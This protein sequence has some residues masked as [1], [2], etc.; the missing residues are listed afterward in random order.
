MDWRGKDSPASELRRSIAEHEGAPTE[1]ADARQRMECPK[2]TALE[3]ERGTGNRRQPCARPLRQ[4]LGWVTETSRRHVE[5]ARPLSG[6][7]AMV[8][9]FQSVQ[10]QA[11]ITNMLP[12]H[13]RYARLLPWSHADLY[14]RLLSGLAVATWRDVVSRLIGMSSPTPP[15]EGRLGRTMLVSGALLTTALLMFST[16]LAG[17]SVWLVGHDRPGDHLNRIPC[18]AMRV[19]VAPR[20]WLQIFGATHGRLAA[21]RSRHCCLSPFEPHSC[22]G[23]TTAMSPTDKV[24]PD[25]N[26]LYLTAPLGAARCRA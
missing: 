20:G 6:Q 7:H 22:P 16:D 3:D 9:I 21:V 5:G 18:H 14:N 10:D 23:S 17:S 2:R 8:T 11:A 13:R 19:S 15:D 1:A 26:A 4:C 25:D 24:E 12:G